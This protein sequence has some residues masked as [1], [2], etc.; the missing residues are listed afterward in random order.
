MAR[1]SLPF[2]RSNRWSF[3]V[4]GCGAM[5]APRLGVI[6]SAPMSRW[7]VALVFLSVSARAAAETSDAAV[8]EAL[9]QAGRAALEQDQV[10]P[11][12]EKFAESQ[13][14]D[15]KLGTLLNLAA[16]HERQK[17]TASSWAEFTQARAQA[18]NARRPDHEAYAE[19]HLQA[20]AGQ[21][22]VVTV[23]WERPAPEQTMAIDGV[24]IG[25][26]AIGTP[27]PLDPGEHV[28]LVSAPGRAPFEHRILVES[29][30]IARVVAIPALLPQPRAH[31][32]S[33]PPD[34]ATAKQR[35]TR[36]SSR[37]S[38]RT[39]VT[40]VAI[41]VGVAGL[42]V[43]AYTGL[44]ALSKK[45]TADT[46]ECDGA[47]CSPRGLEL[48]DQVRK[49]ADISTVAF[50]IGVA[51]LGTGAFLWLDTPGVPAPKKRASLAVGAGPRGLSATLL[52]RF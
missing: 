17:K 21:L 35:P 39:S 38:L 29:G 12:C 13:R 36:P 8:A 1:P 44:T 51:A 40:L 41:G 31:A 19:Q 6:I 49:N 3:S 20:L 45:H 25:A 5:P 47:V 27:L 32:Q 23:N 48:Y 43:G 18:H 30:P 52:A 50:A 15:P 22:S 16:C 7:T 37:L 33:P 42:A 24:T 4:Y 28:V 46:R 10:A 11:A 26:G 9:F 14:L 34:E 2:E